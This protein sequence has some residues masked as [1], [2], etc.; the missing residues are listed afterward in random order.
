MTAPILFRWNGEA[1]EPLQR[2]HNIV[3]GQ[4]VVGQVYRLV[5][6]AVRSQLGGR[7]A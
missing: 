6:E 2:F 5:E 4:F 1:M 3:N 7:W